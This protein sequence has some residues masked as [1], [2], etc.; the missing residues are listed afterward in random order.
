MPTSL[1]TARPYFEIVD[2]GYWCVV[3]EDCHIDKSIPVL[4]SVVR[5]V[6]AGAFDQTVEVHIG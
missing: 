2:M 1:Q 4:T 5:M 3:E 6:D